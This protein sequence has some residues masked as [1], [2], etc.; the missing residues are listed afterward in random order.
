MKVRAW[1]LAGLLALAAGCGGDDGG[2]E[3]SATADWADGI[4]SSTLTWT[5]SVTSTAQSLSGGGLGEEELRGAVDDIE[6]ATKDFAEELKGAGRPDTAA[7]AEVEAAFDDLAGDVEESVAEM[8][9][10]VEDVSG[11]SEVLEAV[12]AVS[13]ILSTMSE[14]VSATLARIET[15]DAQGEIETAF[16]EADSCQ[17]LAESRD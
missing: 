11:V 6:S 7:G 9:T 2:G 1:L 12:T 3:S 16:E 17:E 5:E 14:Q 8:K 13:A 10:A 4:C 15:L